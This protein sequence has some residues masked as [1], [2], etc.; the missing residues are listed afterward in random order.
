MAKTIW[1]RINGWSYKTRDN[2][3]IIQHSGANRC[4]YSAEIDAESTA[5]HGFDVCNEYS[6]TYHSTL[7]EAMNWVESREMKKAVA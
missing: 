2:R 4:W 5:R 3:F 7:R 6:K 1:T